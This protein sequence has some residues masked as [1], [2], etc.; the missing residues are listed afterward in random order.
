[1]ESRGGKPKIDGDYFPGLQHSAKKKFLF[2]LEEELGGRERRGRVGL[3]LF[4][5]GVQEEVG[6][7]GFVGP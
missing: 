1:M 4:G 5:G 7:L 2:D 3:C 6:S